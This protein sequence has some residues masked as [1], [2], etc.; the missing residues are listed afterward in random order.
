V[1]RRYGTLALAAGAASG[2]VGTWEVLD[3]IGVVDF[4]TTAPPSEIARAW[5]DLALDG[6]LADVT[7]HTLRMF[8]AAWVIAV[9]GGALVG[10]LL[11]LSRPVRELLGAS[12]TFMRFVPPPALVPVV[13]IIW[14]FSTSSEVLVAGYAAM[15]PVVV[16]TA[17]GVEHVDPRLIEVGRTLDLGPVARVRKLVLPAALPMLL[18]GVRIATSM[19]LVV[20]VTAEMIGIPR[21]LGYEIVRSSQALRPADALA[22]VVWTGV[23]AVGVA[24]C[25]QAVERRVLRWRTEGTA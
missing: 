17:S 10:A 21:G 5:W 8:A 12:V 2:L 7:A 22:Y 20:V 3:R 4:D 18:T 9:V 13:V 15:W 25:L 24:V 11:G 23:L 19:C 1:R 14:G 16:N 6:R